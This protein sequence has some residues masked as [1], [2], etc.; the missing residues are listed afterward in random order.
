MRRTPVYTKQRQYARWYQL[1]F[2]NSSYSQLPTVHLCTAE[3]PSLRSA[4]M[5][6]ALTSRT[7]MVIRSPKRR[8]APRRDP[9]EAPGAFT[10]LVYLL[11]VSCYPHPSIS[12]QT[13]QECFG[14]P[15]FPLS[16]Y[17]SSFT[18]PPPETFVGTLYP[19]VL[20]L[21]EGMLI[22]YAAGDP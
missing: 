22:W 9:R 4:F 15:R 14:I 10:R 18:I 5:K 2:A 16:G 13:D 21:R 17:P 12:T 19:P 7:T 20:Q 3:S 6:G 8:D 1:D 11:L